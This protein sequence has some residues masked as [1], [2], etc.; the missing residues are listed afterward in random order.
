MPRQAEDSIHF[1]VIFQDGSTALLSLDQATASLGEN[2]AR[3]IA[4][5]RQKLG[6]LWPKP[7]K[8]IRRLN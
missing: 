6:L 7:I 5:E 8:T 3:A 1:E 2:A 4:E